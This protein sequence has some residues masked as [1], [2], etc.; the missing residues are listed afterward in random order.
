MSQVDL[1]Y[2]LQLIDD[3]TNQ[4]K[5]RLG[6][7]LR[8]QQGNKALKEA[9]ELAKT[10]AADLQ[11][12]RSQQQ[13]L[14]LEL[15]SLSDKT[16][17]SEDRLYSGQVKNP[18]ELSDLQSEI[19]SL[20]RRRAALEDEVLE[21]MIMV[22]DAQEESDEAASNLADL[23]S[24]W[25]ETQAKLQVEQD[26]LVQ[27]I[28]ALNQARKEHTQSISPQFLSA[29]DSTLKK[30][31]G[32]AVVKLSNNRC[33]GCLVIVPSNLVKAAYEGKLV[34]CDNCGRILSPA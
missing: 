25:A 27:R 24:E 31:G 12:Y 13:D 16:K 20:N 17:R 8:L 26:E 1:L 15:K 6:E 2:R 9:R 29:Y 3:E 32:T 4:K 21:A 10:A 11:Q 23:E 14:N 28:K 19:D 5:Q 7:V 18:K 34:H 33:R 22:E 30:G